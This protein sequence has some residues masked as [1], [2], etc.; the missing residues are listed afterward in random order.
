VLRFYPN[1]NKKN[2]SPDKKNKQITIDDDIFS[3]NKFVSILLIN[4]PKSD[5]PW[6]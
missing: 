4:F 2:H 3:V 6:E 1:E 5:S